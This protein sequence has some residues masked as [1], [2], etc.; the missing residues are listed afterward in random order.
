MRFTSAW[1]AM[2]SRDAILGRI[3]AALR[4]PAGVETAIS[5][6]DAY[7]HTPA[8]GPLP[9]HDADLVNGFI[10]R[11]GALASCVVGPVPASSVPAAVADYLNG[12]HLPLRA[13]CWPI[14]ATHDWRAVGVDVTARPAQASDAVGITAAFC[15]V[16]ETGSLLLL[17]GHDSEATLSLLPETHI[18]IVPVGRVVAHLEDAF[19]LLRHEHRA[20]PRAVNFVSGPSRTADIEQTVT[21]GAHGPYR[22][23][24]V[25]TA[26]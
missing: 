9:N 21:L 22:V 1:A 14:L 23:L 25:L 7:E 13:V 5:A 19:D 3:R 4:R 10:A 17:S 8:H 18:A 24:I 2:S 15:A 16:A 6:M 12:Q 26:P 11:A 20:M